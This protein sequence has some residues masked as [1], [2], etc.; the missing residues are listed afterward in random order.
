LIARIFSKSVEYARVHV[1][2]RTYF[3]SRTHLPSAVTG[4]H[5]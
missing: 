4:A 5:L 1:V 3:P 2:L